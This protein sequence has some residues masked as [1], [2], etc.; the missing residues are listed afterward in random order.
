MDYVELFTSNFHAIYYTHTTVTIISNVFVVNFF[1]LAFPSITYYND[2]LGY[3]L[4]YTKFFQFYENHPD[5][6]N[7]DYYAEFPDTPKGTVRYWK[8][9][10]SKATNKSP[11]KPISGPNKV[12]RTTKKRSEEAI[13]GKPSTKTPPAVSHPVDENWFE[14]E[15]PELAR[16]T[17]RLVL[18]DAESSTREKLEAASKLVDLKYKSGTLDVKTQSE[19]EVMD[20]FRSQDTRTL[21]NMLRKSSQ[22]EL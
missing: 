10:A 20:K 16:H 11:T 15:D 6:A 8:M 17:Y 13:N 7:K 3:H 12:G 1:I 18:L 9:K 4:S 21:V 2:M 5:L 19:M 22:S 14:M